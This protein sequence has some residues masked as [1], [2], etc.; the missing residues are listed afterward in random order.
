VRTAF[1]PLARRQLARLPEYLLVRH[2]ADLNE[3]LARIQEASTMG[4]QQ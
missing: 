3:H 2:L 4:V 1:P